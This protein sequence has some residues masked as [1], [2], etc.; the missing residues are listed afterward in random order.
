[1]SL[2]FTTKSR[3]KLI[4]FDN[5]QTVAVFNGGMLVMKGGEVLGTLP[6]IFV[7]KWNVT[8]KHY[9]HID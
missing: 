4:S 7:D 9:L 3:Q 6:L 5:H 2:Y 8:L 1:M